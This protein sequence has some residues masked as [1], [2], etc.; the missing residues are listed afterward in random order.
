MVL[1]LT[2]VNGMVYTWDTNRNLL[3]DDVNTYAYDA[4]NT[5]PPTGCR[6]SLAQ[7]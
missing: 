4:A 1:D 5:M 7:L 3:S 2:S 6:L